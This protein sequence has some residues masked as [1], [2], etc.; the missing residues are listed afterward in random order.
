MYVKER[1]Y[2]CSLADTSQILKH[3]KYFKNN[4]DLQSVSLRQIIIIYQPVKLKQS[5]S[6]VHAEGI[7]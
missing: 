4:F 3:L 1:N 7:P 5:K 2:P 6:G